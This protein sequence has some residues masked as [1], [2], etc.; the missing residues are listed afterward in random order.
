MLSPYFVVSCVLVCS[1]FRCA[2][3][4]N[5]Y[6]DRGGEQH[7]TMEE[8]AGLEHLQDGA[9]FM[10]CGFGAI[11]GL[12]EMRIKLFAERIDALDAEASD[13]VDELLVDK[14]EAFAIIFVLSFA[15][16]GK[17]VLE[18]VDDGD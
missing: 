2:A 8:I 17:R 1:I 10:N 6:A 18:T 12:M 13:V 11:H 4:V 7:A 15:M 14:L 5:G 16:S 3:R 9:V